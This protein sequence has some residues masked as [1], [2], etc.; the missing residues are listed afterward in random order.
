MSIFVPQI[1]NLCHGRLTSEVD[2]QCGKN[3]DARMSCSR[4]LLNGGAKT[5]IHR[6]IHQMQ[7]DVVGWA[8]GS[9][10]ERHAQA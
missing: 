7:N 3:A 8:G 4:D 9:V 2:G 10:G 1:G 6:T 5:L